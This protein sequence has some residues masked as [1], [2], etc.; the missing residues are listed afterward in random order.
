MW[1][2]RHVILPKALCVRHSSFVDLGLTV[3]FDVIS[4]KQIK[5]EYFEDTGVLRILSDKV[6]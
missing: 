6:R 5:P 2:Y 4:L 3:F 1:E